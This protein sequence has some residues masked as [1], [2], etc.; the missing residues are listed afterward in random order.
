V[1]TVRE[2]RIMT[3]DLLALADWLAR[4]GVTHVA[5]ESSGVYRKPVW[6]LLEAQGTPLLV[7]AQHIEAVPGRKT[8][9]GDAAWI[10]NLVQ[11]G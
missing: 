4:E 8:D 11:H 3:G 9:V 5:M 2:F 7:N 10:A 1:Q 6:N